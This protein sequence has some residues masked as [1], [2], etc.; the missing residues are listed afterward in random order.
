M[1]LSEGAP[2]DLVERL[3]AFLRQKTGAPW[4]IAISHEIGHTTLHQ[5]AE[6]RLGAQREALLR[7]PLIKTL[8]DAFPDATLIQENKT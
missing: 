6:E 7:T 4:T 8:M 1:R 2:A 5:K 3:G